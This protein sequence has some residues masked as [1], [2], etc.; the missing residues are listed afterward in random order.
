[1]YDQLLSNLR[2]QALSKRGYWAEDIFAALHPGCVRQ[3]RGGVDFLVDGEPVDVKSTMKFAG[4]DDPGRAYPR[5]TGPRREGVAY[6]YVVFYR[7]GVVVTQDGREPFRLSAET[8]AGA[9]KKSKSPAVAKDDRLEVLKSEI[10]DLVPGAHIIGRNYSH[11]NWHVSGPNNLIPKKEVWATVFIRLNGD[12]VT[13]Y[14]FRRQD[15]QRLPLARNHFG[16]MTVAP[17]HFPPEFVFTSPNEVV[18][19]LAPSKSQS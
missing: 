12:S 5:Y 2:G 4:I 18:R 15:L 10:K 11:A 1:V 8:A 16:R 7:D 17:V 3:N 13:Y 6:P 14:A 19:A 9:Y